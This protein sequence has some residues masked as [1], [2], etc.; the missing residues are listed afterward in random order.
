MQVVDCGC[1][2]DC[3]CE[4][5]L[6]P[7]VYHNS[8]DD[9]DPR[10]ELRFTKREFL[11]G[12]HS[13][14]IVDESS[15]L[16]ER[17]VQDLRSFGLPVLLVGDHGQLPPVKAKMNPWIEH[18]TVTLAVNHRQGEESGI[19]E[20]AEQARRSGKLSK[21]QYGSAVHVL[22]VRGS[23]AEALLERFRPDA[24]EATVLVQYNR[25]RASLNV[26]FRRGEPLPV[27]T[28]ERIISLERQEVPELHDGQVV[29]ELL[30]HSGTLA[31]VTAVHSIGDRYCTVEAQ[32]DWDLRGRQDTHVLLRLASAQ[33]GSADN[34]SYRS[35]PGGTVLWD[36]AYA[37]TAHKAQGSEFDNV[38]VW[39]ETPGDKRWIYTAITRG[40]KAVIVLVL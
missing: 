34:L 12:Q 7:C 10:E 3:D 6:V 27:I 31:T 15:M 33:L 35:K 19:P 23:S 28:G 30:I 24:K 37:L 22:D 38:I 26:Y 18:P 40:K 13:F 9:C 21:S 4:S 1:G 8:A 29:N 39:Q 16:T 20:A 11:S 32:L 14:I 2:N 17:E 25:T 36:Y 5:K